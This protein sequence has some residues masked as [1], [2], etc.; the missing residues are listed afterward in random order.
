MKPYLQVLSDRTKSSVNTQ[1]N[2]VHRSSLI[3]PII[4]DFDA[5]VS[6]LN[7]FYLKRGYKNVCLKITPYDKDGNPQTSLSHEINEP[8]VYTFDLP[9]QSKDSQDSINS[10]ELE[11]FCSSNLFVPFPA[12][13]INHT[14][15]ECINIVH[16]YNRNL[17]DFREYQKISD[18]VTSE[19]S[20]EY[21]NNEKLETFV[22]FQDCRN[23]RE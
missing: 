19:A 21:I 15:T 5:Q 22:I 9:K 4:D 1:H 16:S 17:N 7:H 8:I 13:M 12:V 14:S 18:V 11:F 2:A 20:F 6:F 3:V 23:F 10:Y